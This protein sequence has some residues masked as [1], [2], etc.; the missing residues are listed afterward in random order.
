MS[1]T[2]VLIISL[3]CTAMCTTVVLT[4]IKEVREE[5]ME[6]V[7]ERF[8]NIG[9]TIAE[10]RENMETTAVLDEKATKEIVER[11]ERNWEASVE[12]IM[13]YDPFKGDNE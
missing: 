3:F 7:T 6:Y 1:M 8:I 4:R 9:M 2:I 12:K 11:F 10:L 5:I 13:N